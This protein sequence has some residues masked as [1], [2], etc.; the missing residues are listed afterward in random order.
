MVQKKRLGLFCVLPALAAGLVNYSSASAQDGRASQPIKV[1]SHAS[2]WNYP[3][4]IVLRADQKLH[5]VENGDTL[6]DLGQKYLGS[7]YAWPQIWELNRW[8]EDPHWIY[9]GDPLLIPT[10][11]RAITQDAL[12]P[13]PSVADLPPDTREVRDVSSPPL[14]KVIPASR[15]S[16]YAYAFQD[17][18]QLPY[19]VPKGAAAHF[20]ELEAIRITGNQKED[21]RV[22]S[23]GDV[24]YLGSGQD[25]GLQV[26]DRY[27]VLKV[28]KSKLIHPDDKRGRNPCGDVIKHAAIVRAL[29]IHPENSEAIIEETLDGVEI[30]D[31]AAAYVEPALIHT[32][33]A[34]LIKNT[35]EP[36]PLNTTAKIIYGKNG[37]TYFGAGSLVLIDKGVQAGL[38]VGDVL[39]AVRNKPLINE[40]ASTKV[41]NNG[42]QTNRYLGQLLVVRSDDT[43]STCLVMVTKAEMTIGDIVTN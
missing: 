12:E 33:D 24:V 26:G 23:K 43:S 27:L 32:K 41:K 30:G 28:A 11:R 37:A 29:S 6:W 34:P 3:R 5:I 21:R 42:P 4:E 35:Q 10:E 36:I 13:D 40:G 22:L 18:L 20:K 7:P 1:E 8:V 31:H 25:K 17:F 16:G 15:A 39:L 9:P 14:I 2:R 19:L 38:K